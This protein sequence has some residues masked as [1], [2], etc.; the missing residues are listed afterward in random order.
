[1][2]KERESVTIK[3]T[4]A[5]WLKAE[6]H[7]H[8]SLDPVDY[9]VCSHSAEQLISEAA[10]LR[11][12]ILAITCHDRDIWSTELSDYAGSLGITLI[13]GMEVSTGDGRHVLAFNFRTG[14]ENL[15]TLAKIRSLSRE[16]TL[17]IAP[18]PYFPSS[19]CLGQRLEQNIEV[20]DAIESSGFWIPGLDF[21]RRAR[22][23]ALRHA[24]PLV[25]NS[26]VHVLWQLGRTF[27]WIQAEPDVSSIIAAV[28]LGR[29]RLET[30]ALFYPEALRFWTTALWRFVF[31]A[32]PPPAGGV[33][34]LEL[35]H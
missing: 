27:T 8:C 13:P 28:K 26:D 22:K 23:V 32:N 3:T 6:L 20:F 29:V 11:Y 31:P 35:S 21:N 1:M 15:N 17:V 25:G 7:S 19:S 24:K 30:T 12:D 14:S 34:D 4:Q 16:D 33:G 2:L 18:H 10:R 9:R 5:R